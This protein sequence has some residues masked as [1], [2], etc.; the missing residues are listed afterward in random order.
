M[1]RAVSLQGHPGGAGM[2][3]SIVLNGV[4]GQG[5]ILAARALGMAAVAQGYEV[6]A[7]ETI[8]MA[9]REG[10]VVSHVRIGRDL[11]GPLIPD[12][13]AD[14]LLGFELLEAVRGRGKL[15]PGGLSL[16]N[17]ARIPPVPV[18]IGLAR[19]DD[20]ALHSCLEELEAR[21]LL[22]DAT[23]LAVRAGSYRATNAVMLG[24]LAETGCLPFPAE[25]LLAAVLSLVPA[26]STGVNRE[27]FEAGRRWYHETVAA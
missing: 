19:Y 3:V 18:N 21:V 16:V 8:G 9:Q 7:A 4:G 6:R 11:G 20:G 27:A 24:I 26:R 13:R 23:D 12:G 17:V 15:R 14:V 22:V 25:P 10:A 5:T 2:N 1:R